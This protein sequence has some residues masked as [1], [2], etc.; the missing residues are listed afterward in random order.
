[1]TPNKSLSEKMQLIAAKLE[2]QAAH[3]KIA[4]LRGSSPAFLAA[5]LMEKLPV[6]F[7]VVLP[8]SESAEEFY[9]EARFYSVRPQAIY[10]F[11]SWETSP[12]EQS[13]PHPDISGERLSTLAALLE[14]KASMIVLPVSALM[15]RVLPRSVL[16]DHSQYLVVGEEIDR[17]A[18]LRKLV[19]LGYSMVPL[20]EDRGSASVRGG[21]VDMFLPSLANPVRIEFFGDFVE[22]IRTFDPVTQRSLHPLEEL[23][24][25]PS[26]EIILSESVVQSFAPRLKGRCDALGIPATRRRELLEQLQQAIYPPGVEYLQPLFHPGLETLFDYAAGEVVVVEVDTLSV[27][28]S[29]TRFAAD[30]FAAEK[31]AEEKNAIFS[32]GKDLCLGPDELTSLLAEMRMI[33]IPF[34]EIE[35][36]GAASSSVRFSVL[37]NEDLKLTMS[38]DSDGVLRPLV[39]RLSLWLEEKSRVFIACHQRSQIQRL[40]ELLRPYNLPLTF[41]EEPFSASKSAD[42]QGVQLIMGEISRGFR[43]VE[44]NLVV[45]CEEEIFGRR[46]KRRDISEIRKKQILVSLE[47]LKPCLLYTSPSPR[48]GLLSRMP[49]S[50]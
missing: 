46:V 30:F 42:G 43:L 9:R 21:I 37:E 11:P 14:G 10:Y 47:E 50:A 22:S 39:D 25:L 32:Q 41:T 18:F 26:R 27:Q 29:V 12:F 8:D 16:A 45:I 20:V 15:Q 34:L 40:D 1:M 17:D 31:R 7:F 44:E 3:V 38:S 49:S 33:S 48:D 6:P 24:V 2:A 36:R 4:G 19:D 35:E 23:V 28:E 5:S 13:S